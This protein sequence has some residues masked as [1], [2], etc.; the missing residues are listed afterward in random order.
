MF[1]KQSQIGANNGKYARNPRCEAIAKQKFTKFKSSPVFQKVTKPA[2][3]AGCEAVGEAVTPEDESQRRST[4][5][6][7]AFTTFR[8]AKKSTSMKA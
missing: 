3:L 5:R 4:I 6:Q 8:G 7:L 2:S 1:K